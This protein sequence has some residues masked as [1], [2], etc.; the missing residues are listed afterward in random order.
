MSNAPLGEA[1]QIAA[2]LR[3]LAAKID[4]RAGADASHS[5]TAQLLAKG[6]AACAKKLGEEG[7]ELALAVSSQSEA[8]VAAEAGD[9]LYHLL[10]ALRVRGVSLDEVAA[11]LAKR[12]GQS[13]LAEKATRKP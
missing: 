12:Q 3:E 1:S 4:A 7:V 2:A 6:P 13:G 8:E 5:Y 9:V 11:V 10:V